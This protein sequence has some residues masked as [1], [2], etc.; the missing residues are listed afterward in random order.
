MNMNM[1]FGR[2]RSVDIRG[3]AGRP[4]AFV[5]YYDERDAED[6]IYYRDGYVQFMCAS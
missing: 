2:I 6:A 3:G 1:Q 4:F 5:E